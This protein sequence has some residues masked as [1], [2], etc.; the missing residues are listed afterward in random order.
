MLNIYY[1]DGIT[2]NLK[3]EKKK[4]EKMRTK[5][6]EEIEKALD[7]AIADQEEA[8]GRSEALYREFLWHCDKN[9]PLWADIG[10]EMKNT[11]QYTKL[12]LE[13]VRKLSEI[14]WSRFGP[15]ED[16]NHPQS[17]KREKKRKKK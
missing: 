9:K 6:K 5:T 2:P 13:N 12:D 15:R 10:Y 8:Q 3:N 7:Q 16:E 17:E 11:Y 1:S 4:E 14:K